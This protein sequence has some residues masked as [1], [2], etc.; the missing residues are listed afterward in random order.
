MSF[1]YK[2]YHL[3]RADFLERVRR[4]SFLVMLGAVVFLGYQVAIGNMTLRLDQYR[5]I[6]NSAWVGSMMSLISNFFLGWF[7]FYLI[8]G[9]IARDRETGVGQIMATTPLTRALYMLGKF[10]SNLSVLLAMNAVLILASIVIQWLAGESYQIDLPALLAPFVFVV[11]PL[12]ALVSAVAVLFESIG[13]LSGG[14]GN[15][16]YFFGF[17]MFMPLIGNTSIHPAVEPIGLSLMQSN[18]SRALIA[19][20]PD[21]SGGFVL[22]SG[23]DDPSLGIDFEAAE[24]IFLWSGVD[25]TA[26]IILIRAA[27]LALAIGLTLFASLFFDRFDPSRSKPRRI[28]S[29]A[30]LPMPVPVS[31]PQ[32]VSQPIHLT[33]PLSSSTNR[34]AF[35]RV[36]IS[37]LKLLLK[38]QRWWWYLIAFGFIVAG[39][40]N[41][42]ENARQFVLMFTWIWPLLIWSGLGNREKY[43]QTHQMVFSSAAPLMRQLPAQWTAGFLVTALT[44]SGVFLNLLF[45]G[46]T[47]GLIA[48]TSAA[49]FIPSFALALG[50]WSNSHKLFEVLYMCL[51]YIGPLNRTPA[52]DFLGASGGGNLIFF[53]PF[54]IGLIIVAFAGRARQLQN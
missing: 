18:M 30:S 52:V 36:L 2:I 49:I 34:F 20:H 27:Y 28:K 6:F 14:F 54:S 4:Y 32:T 42:P 53:I 37:E 12:M 3:A 16:V 25:W 23:A 43:N 26:N 24:Q 39:I 7:G 17:I 21:Y 1:A 38:G 40:S 13:F 10:A 46:D 19:V 41:T 47:T 51:W 22:G 11:L 9:S 33:P 31:T 45:A 35:A 29:T 5:G 50:V 15:V 8:K 44:G 48:W